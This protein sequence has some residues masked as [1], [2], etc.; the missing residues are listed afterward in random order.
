VSNFKGINNPNF[1]HGETLIKHY[2]SCGNEINYYTFMYGTKQCRQCYLKNSI[3]KYYCIDCGKELSRKG[4]KRCYSCNTKG[5]RNVM[6]GKEGCNL[7]KHLSKETKSKLSLTHGG[8]GIPYENY[9][10]PQEFYNLK[11]SIRKR[12]NYECQNC[13]MTEEEHLIVYGQ[14]LN[15]HHIDYNKENCRE[16]NLIS[17][18]ITCNTRANYNRDY[19]KYFYKNKI[20]GIYE[21][22]KVI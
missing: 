16:K 9:E 7:G 22:Y 8:T 4:C 13:G 5:K 14:V 2:C 11:E 21:N 17:T 3:K 18:C 19:W 20:K 10:Y 15:I 12:D 1:K 6:F